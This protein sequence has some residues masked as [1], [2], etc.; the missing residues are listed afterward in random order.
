M[1]MHRT[2]FSSDSQGVEERLAARML[3]YS[4]PWVP[5]ALSC[6]LLKCAAS[7]EG[8]AQCIPPL[9]YRAERDVLC[10]SAAGWDTA[11]ERTGSIAARRD[12]YKPGNGC[13]KASF[14]SAWRAARF[15]FLVS[16]QA[17]EIDSNFVNLPCAFTR[18]KPTG[19]PV[20]SVCQNFVDF[21]VV[22]GGLK[23]KLLTEKKR[24]RKQR[25]AVP[26]SRTMFGELERTIAPGRVCVQI[27]DSVGEGGGGEIYCERQ[28]RSSSVP[29]G[30]REEQHIL[31]DK[32][33]R[34]AILCR[35]VKM[36]VLQSRDCF[37]LDRRFAR[38]TCSATLSKKFCGRGFARFLS[39]LKVAL[40][41]EDGACPCTIEGQSVFTR[42][43]HFCEEFI[44][45][46]SISVNHIGG[47]NQT[48]FGTFATSRSNVAA[49][50]SGSV[51]REPNRGGS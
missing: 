31:V 27:A 46:L 29:P 36:C 13:K 45:D 32:L 39:T 21:L 9:L 1:D 5:I 48:S 16:S 30:V 12:T 44:H 35:S 51:L 3:G 40:S 34:K 41:D 2:A 37:A 24:R 10:I 19:E 43:A 47:V 18:G 15:T 17:K 7:R 25:L 20:F 50:L 38:K 42:I 22:V 23:K 6:R 28:E 4:S 8:Q 49:P 11:I 14:F 33:G 26:D